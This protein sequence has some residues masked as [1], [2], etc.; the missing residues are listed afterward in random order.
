MKKKSAS[1]SAFFNLR[2]LIGLF[3]VLSGVF[4]ALAGLGT[5]SASAFSP[6]KAQQKKTKILNIPGLPPGFDCSKIHELGIDRMEGFRAGRIMIACG[7]AKGGS[8]SPYPAFSR[9]LNKLTDRVVPRVPLAYG[10]ADVDLVTGT[11]TSPHIT[12]SETYTTANPDNPDEICVAFNDSRDV[13]SN[14]IDISA[15]S[16]STDGGTTFVRLTAANGQS[17]FTNTLGDPVTLYNSPTGTWFATFL[18]IGCG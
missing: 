11:E 9:L 1:R 13:A 8:A 3:V 12:Q 15:A 6:A 5:F 10:A 2:V 18:D 14:P 7:E 4:L 16:V 17:P